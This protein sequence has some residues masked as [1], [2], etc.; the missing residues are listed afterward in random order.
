VLPGLFTTDQAVLDEIAVPWWF[1]VGQLTVAG[2]VFALDGVL[3]GAGDAKF[4]RNATLASALIGFLPLI[5]LSLAY[6]WGLVGIWSG[7]SLF[8]VLRLV[9]VGWRTFSGR[10]LVAG[11]G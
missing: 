4:M 3:L 11:V 7:L 10:W 9:F 6:G 2:I 5:W 8:M 1:L